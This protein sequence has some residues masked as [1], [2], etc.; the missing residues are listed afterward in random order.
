MSD[1]K[2]A[3]GVQLASRFVLERC[4]GRGGMGEVWAAENTHTG[5]RVAVKIVRE[6]IARSS[7][8]QRLVREARAAGS[9]EHPN[10]CEVLDVVMHEGA[11]ILVMPLLRGETLAERLARVR[12]LGPTE[13][14]AV[15]ARVAAGVA[16]AHAA[17][18][19]HRDLKPANIFLEDSGGVR[20]LDFGIAKFDAQDGEKLTATGSILGT[21][22]YMSPE[23]ALGE[24]D[25]D[26]QSDV[27]SLGIVLFECI[28]GS[29][30]TD[31]ENVGQTL[32]RILFA[33]IPRLEELEPT[34]PRELSELVGRMLERSRKKRVSDLREVIDVL[35]AVAGIERPAAAAPRAARASSEGLEE[36]PAGGSPLATTT[37]AAERTSDVTR[38]VE[39]EPESTEDAG[40]PLRG[41]LPVPSST[42]PALPL[43]SR[44]L[45]ALAGALLGLGGL[46]AVVMLVRNE[47]VIEAAPRATNAEP[48]PSQPAPAPPLASTTQAVPTQEAGLPT[49]PSP[50]ATAEAATSKARLMNSRA[51]QPAAPSATATSSVSL[52]EA[53][54]DR[55]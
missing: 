30:P 51:S 24:K 55:R 22:A 11:P 40:A 48:T 50:S 43:R 34:V 7:H 12:T 33:P 39:P 13:A 44:N 2:L 37:S 21:P 15:I 32:K 26:H 36:F 18:I 31:A 4:L 41:A 29:V 17:G 10:V 49:A 38:A 52:K 53:L 14:S 46:V 28:A 54:R 1:G 45:P 27:W 6:E 47:P 35:A 25:L 8:A 3:P 16:A 42:L 19:V 9:L 20:V 23:Q 5:R